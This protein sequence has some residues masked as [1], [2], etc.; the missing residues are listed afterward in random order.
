MA[1]FLLWI[2][3]YLYLWLLG[4]VA[5]HVSS[6]VFHA[7]IVI[8]VILIILIYFA[9]GVTGGDLFIRHMQ[10]SARFSGM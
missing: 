2:G 4:L 1:R 7:L 9:T 6:P 3:E 8:G 10:Q 5:F